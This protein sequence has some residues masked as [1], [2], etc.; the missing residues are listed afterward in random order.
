MKIAIIGMA[1]LAISC[2]VQKP[3][4]VAIES[5]LRV[6]ERIVEIPAVNDSAA[7]S[8]Y[9]ECDSNNRVILK[10]YDELM[11]DYVSLK[12]LMTPSGKGMHLSVD[13]KTQ[14]PATQAKVSDS[15]LKKQVPVFV[16]GDT[17]EVDKPPSW[18][19]QF[20]FYSGIVAWIF[21][22]SLSGFKIY[23]FLKH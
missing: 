19:E 6:T 21:L 8:A 4:Q 15:T 16:K 18:L 12:S 13:L 22:L 9:F 1:A 14:R 23:K 5:E 17:V 2:R 7:I 11:S 20:F 3:E 10:K